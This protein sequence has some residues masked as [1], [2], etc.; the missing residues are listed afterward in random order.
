MVQ[1]RRRPRGVA[2]RHGPG[3][4]L[5]RAPWSTAAQGRHH[6]QGQRRRGAGRGRPAR[7]ARPAQRQGDGRRTSPPALSRRRMPP[8]KADVRA[9]RGGLLG[10]AGRAGPGEPD[11]D[12]LDAAGA[13]QAGDQPRRVRLLLRPL[14]AEL[15]RLGH[16]QLRHLGGAVRPGAVRPGREDQGDRRQGGLLRGVAAAEDRRDGGDR[17]AGVAGGRRRGRALRRQPRPG[18][19][20]RRHLPRCRAAQHRHDREGTRWHGSDSTA[21][22]FEQASLAYGRARWSRTSTAW[23][24][25]ARRS[26]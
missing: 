1:Q 16:P 5:L 8:D 25:P 20:A 6:P 4:R 11:Q 26:P 12:R 2:R 7:L 24:A 3:G 15:R 19:V 22:R 10:Q 18:G 13:A 14:R 9:E 23:C 21:L 17:E